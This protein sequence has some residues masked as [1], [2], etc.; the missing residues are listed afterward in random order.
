MVKTLKMMK[1]SDQ[2]IE[3]LTGLA[4]Q[5][6]GVVI[7]VRS[8]AGDQL[9]GQLISGAVEHT[10]TCRVLL[11]ASPRQVR[12]RAHELRH[13]I[14]SSASRH[15][16]VLFAPYFSLQSQALCREL[17][18]G[19]VDCVGNAWLAV[20]HCLIVSQTASKPAVVKRQLKSLFKPKSAAVLKALVSQ[21]GKHWRVAELAHISGASLGLVSKVKQ[22]LL[23]REWA[24][25]ST[26]GLRLSAPDALLDQWQSSHQ[27]VAG[28]RLVFYTT[29]HG[30]SLERK[31]RSCIESAPTGAAICL[32]SFS[33]AQWIAPYARTGNQY[34]YVN[35][36]GLEHLTT[37]LDLSPSLNGGVFV[38]LLENQDLFRDT[39]L[40]LDGMRCT[41]IVQT[42]LDLSLAGERGQEAAAFL[43][44]K[45]LNGNTDSRT[46]SICG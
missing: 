5:L 23:E 30:T 40:P 41:G 6:P 7:T 12:A 21:P 8:V 32:A 3:V 18:V 14:E 4:S 10:L 38:T 29:W 13:A 2:A 42:Y 35:E 37:S 9:T 36:Q 28:E 20:D 43:R 19:Y 22:G 31:L 15:V 16:P 24:C 26:N 27:P 1:V 33:A 44:Q 39:F 46:G 11:D 25:A 34:L 45:V 17:G